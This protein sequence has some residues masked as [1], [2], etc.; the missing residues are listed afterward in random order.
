MDLEQVDVVRLQ[1][2]EGFL[3]RVED[4]L[5]RE[6]WEAVVSNGFSITVDLCKT[7]HAD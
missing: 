2:F 3:D 5:S 6:A 4:G 7:H 1:P